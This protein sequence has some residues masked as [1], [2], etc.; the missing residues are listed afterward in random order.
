MRRLVEDLRDPGADVVA[1]LGGEHPA[2]T[3]RV[4]YAERGA[5]LADDVLRRGDA[6]QL[7]EVHDRLLGLAAEQVRQ[8][9]LARARRARGSR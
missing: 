7:D 5:D 6:D 8:P 9:G 4:A 2:A 3:D 1:L